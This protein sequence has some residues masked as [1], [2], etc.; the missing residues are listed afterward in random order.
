MTHYVRHYTHYRF[1]RKGDRVWINNKSNLI[2]LFPHSQDFIT[3]GILSHIFSIHMPAPTSNQR[4][5]RGLHDATVLVNVQKDNKH[6]HDQYNAFMFSIGKE[7]NALHYQTKQ[8]QTK[9]HVKT[10]FLFWL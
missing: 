7:D 3:F 2:I 1:S 8:K 5:I 4:C 6:F 9:R 10:F